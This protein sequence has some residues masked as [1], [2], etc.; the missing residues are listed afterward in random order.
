MSN[1]NNL[2]ENQIIER[3]SAHTNTESTFDIADQF[4]TTEY[5]KASVLIPLVK[6][7]NNWHVLFIRRA[8]SDKDRHSGQVAF[9]GGKAETSDDSE[10]DTALR[11]TQEEIGV[12]PKDVNVLGQIGSHYSV[13][14]FQITPVIATLPWPYDLKLEPGEVGHTFTYP[15]SWLADESNYEI[16][17]RQPSESNKQVP[18]IFFKEHE[19]ELL[20]GATARMMISFIKIL[21]SI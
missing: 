9:V 13:S 3:L 15:L 19:G 7:N 10:I 5:K 16:R 2:T 17:N 6:K 11:E 4:A 20:W 21:K 8:E 1:L 12:N 14:R 18:V